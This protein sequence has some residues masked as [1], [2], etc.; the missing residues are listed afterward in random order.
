MN[1]LRLLPV[2]LLICCGLAEASTLYKC[3]DADGTVLFTNQKTKNKGCT[4]LSQDNSPAP[5]AA[6]KS[7]TATPTPSNFPRVSGNEQKARDGDRRTI[8]EQE[9]ATE[10]KN[11]D[12]AK[13]AADAGKTQLHERNIEAL[14]K[15]VA[16]LK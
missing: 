1:I 12:A 3:T 15:E 7:H 13:Q 2:V 14:R 8:L 6:G 16:R 4:V 9:L 5:K 11:L 10:Q